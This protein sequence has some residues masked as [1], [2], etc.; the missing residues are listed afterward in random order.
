MNKLWN[1]INGEFVP[2]QSEK[3]LESFNPATGKPHLLVSD[4]DERDVAL[5]VDSAK[6]A[7]TDWSRTKAEE[8]AKFLYRIADLIDE[9]K[10]KLAEAESA[11]QGKPVW[12]ASQMDISRA[13][14]NFRFFAGTILHSHDRAT[15]MDQTAFNY[16]SRKPLGV[17]GLISPWNLPLYLL[18]WK[19]APAIAFG[20]TAVAKPSEFTSHTAYLL[21]EIFQE[22]ELPNGVVNMIFGTGPRAG[23]ALVTH[24]D[25]PLISF[26]GGTTTGRAIATA[27]APMFKK[28]SLELGGK[29]PNII[30]DDA[31]LEEAVRM[32]IRSSFL[33]QGEIC[34]CG[35]RL[36]VQRGIY[37]EF[38]EKFVAQ[39]KALKVGDPR[40]KDTFLGPLVSKDHL[41]KV[42]SFLKHARDEGIQIL[43][44]G[45]LPK[46][47]AELANGYFLEP[48]VFA[49][50]KHV[51]RIQQEEIFG[52]VVS[53]TPFDTDEEAIE[54]ANG[55]TYGLSATVWTKSLQRAHTVA[56]ELHAGTVWVNTWLMRDLRLPFGGVKASGLGRE[57]QEESFEFFTEAKTI[58][59]KH[60]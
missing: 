32:S 9:R 3:Y 50:V 11:D 56:E 35:S 4:S 14:H 55:V 45:N 54:M 51:S 30:F 6:T 10:V 58:C 23:Q 29:N 17:A 25:V 7:F 8:R 59:I 53:I 1:F 43:A 40:E 16:T 21:C 34:L 22:A 2:P 18:T 48:T 42:E 38:V 60:G 52:P 27:A 47:S 37:N 36:Y 49:G 26:T 33:N 12:L 19:I 39:A 20:N 15:R 46:L 57:G 28:L 24:P 31:D 13:S 5:A 44:G 41:E